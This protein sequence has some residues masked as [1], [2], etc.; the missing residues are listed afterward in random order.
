M[1]YPV[2]KFVAVENEVNNSV[3]T[4]CNSYI[5]STIFGFR[6]VQKYVC[7]LLFLGFYFPL[8]KKISTK[9]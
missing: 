2:C 8:N 5:I 6:R 9:M 7:H 1:A 4:F 3:E